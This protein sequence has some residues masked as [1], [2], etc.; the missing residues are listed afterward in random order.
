MFVN[1]ILSC[2]LCF[3]HMGWQ[4]HVGSLNCTV[5]FAQEPSF[6]M[7]LSQKRPR[8]LKSLLAVAN[9]YL[10]NFSLSL[11]H[12]SFSSDA[13]GRHRCIKSIHHIDTSNRMG[14]LRLV[15]SLKF[16]VSLQNRVSF[17]GLFCKRDLSF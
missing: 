16:K 13:R 12:F 4:W 10:L 1:C 15:G 7:A 9:R 11:F 3:S 2:V 8:N 5:F 14:W 17:I 6:C